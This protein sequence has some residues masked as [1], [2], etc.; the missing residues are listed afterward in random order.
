M[1]F[2]L[3]RD[4][5]SERFRN[6]P[7]RDLP[8]TFVDAITLVKRLGTRYLWIDSL[9]IIQDDADDWARE[10]ARMSDVY[11]GAHLVVS[12][13]WAEDVSQGCFHHRDSRSAYPIDILPELVSKPLSPI[14]EVYY[15]GGRFPA[16]PLA[17]RS[18]AFQERV[19]AQRVIH[20]TTQQVYYECNNGI[21][22]EDGSSQSCR[23]SPINQGPEGQDVWGSRLKLW[24]DLVGEYG[25]RKL[26]RTTDKLPAISGLA[27]I[28]GEK[29]EAQ[30]LAGVWSDDIIFG[31]TWG[32]R[33]FHA[34]NPPSEYVAPSWSWA[35]YSGIA[36]S[37][38]RLYHVKNVAKVLGWNIEPKNKAD[39]YGEVVDA[40]LRIRAP[41][42]PLIPGIVHQL[43]ATTDHRPRGP[44]EYEYDFVQYTQM[45]NA[46]QKLMIMRE[47]VTAKSSRY[48]CLIVTGDGQRGQ[49]KRIG[50]AKIPKAVGMRMVQDEES[51]VTI[52]LV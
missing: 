47:E 51:W 29:H 34:D 13:D 8:K 16:E 44:V 5:I 37:W 11:S 18:W 40:S 24:Y 39:P 15:D 52:V 30:Y 26:T 9:C 10:S 17:R 7:L 33:G 43:N 49:M 46:E 31:I 20:Y 42:T 41:I 2:T 6:I 35:S 48:R 45:E 32:A 12:V 3:T 50:R 23:F 25:R 19:L 36:A 28:I 38:D 27:R 1:P 22:A 21:V 14:D 4:S